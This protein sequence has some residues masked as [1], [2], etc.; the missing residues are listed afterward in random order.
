MET[1]LIGLTVALALLAAILYYKGFISPARPG[2]FN[3]KAGFLVLAF[4]L[5]PAVRVMVI[6]GF[7]FPT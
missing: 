2:S 3:S 6:P 7:S 1:S 4:V 5:I